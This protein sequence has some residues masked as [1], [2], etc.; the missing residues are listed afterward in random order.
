MRNGADGSDLSVAKGFE[1]ARLLLKR[2][3]V[4]HEA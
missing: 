2:V 4:V 3:K 1:G